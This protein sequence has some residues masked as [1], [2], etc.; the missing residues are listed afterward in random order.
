MK[1]LIIGLTKHT[2]KPGPHSSRGMTLSLSIA[3]TMTTLFIVSLT[4][5]MM[6]LAAR[7]YKKRQARDNNTKVSEFEVEG[8]PCYEATE[9]KQMGDAE[10]HVY[11]MIREK[12]G[13]Q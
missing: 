9:M 5:N 12:R 2:C 4:I 13:Q 6:V 7:L 8:N 3:I 10:T 11:E 1:T